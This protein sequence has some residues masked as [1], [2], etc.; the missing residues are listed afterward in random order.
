MAAGWFPGCIGCDHL[1]LAASL[2]ARQDPAVTTE[3]PPQ[4]LQI[5]DRSRRAFVLALLLFLLGAVVA[6]LTAVSSMMAFSTVLVGATAWS[7]GGRAG[8]VAMLLSKLVSFAVMAAAGHS[9]PPAHPALVLLPVLLTESFVVA[10]AAGLRR[11]AQTIRAQVLELRER[12]LALHSARVEIQGLRELL[13]VC[14]WCGA[15]RDASGV[16]RAREQWLAHARGSSV[17]HGICPECAAKQQ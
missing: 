6:A 14:A 3:A 15:V 12:N 17:T 1:L 11:N 13:P 2:V 16:W 5:P 8:V 10:L 4:E 7:F 9:E